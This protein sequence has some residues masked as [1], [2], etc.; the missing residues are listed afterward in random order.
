MARSA[1]RSAFTPFTRLRAYLLL[2]EASGMKWPPCSV[3]ARYT[4]QSCRARQIRGQF[5]T[6][7]T[8]LG[9]T[10]A[11][12]FGSKESSRC[13]NSPRRRDSR[14]FAS[15]TRGL[16]RLQ[17]WLDSKDSECGLWHPGQAN[18]TRPLNSADWMSVDLP[19]PFGPAI[20]V[21]IGTQCYAA[22]DFNSRTTS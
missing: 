21:R 6:R 10:N 11:R 17:Q 15:G 5:H 9:V 12:S 18:A 19:D 2:T 1:I 22:R 16:P 20:S 3:F 13:Q 14:R 7:G 8:W 4:S